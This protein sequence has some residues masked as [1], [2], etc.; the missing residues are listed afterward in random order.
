M[1]LRRR[2]L[3]LGTGVLAAALLAVGVGLHAYVEGPR[4]EAERERVLRS[5]EQAALLLTL[6]GSGRLDLAARAPELGRLLGVRVTLVASDGTVLG[7]SGVPGGDVRNMENHGRRPEVLAALQGRRE[8]VERP[9]P[10]QGIP[11][12]YVA[13]LHALVDGDSVVV[14]VAMPVGSLRGPLDRA[15]ALLLVLGG[16]GFLLLLGLVTAGAADGVLQRGLA[17]MEGGV[18]RATQGDPGALPTPEALPPELRSLGGGLH[19]LVDEVQGR[20]REVLRDRDEL[21][22]L[23]EAIAEGVVALTEDARVLRMNRAAIRLLDVV[24]PAPFAPIGTLVRQPQLRDH[25]EESVVL[26]LPPREFLVGGRNL[27]VS[28]Q[29]LEEGGS[30]VTL[31]DVTE[32]RRSE[33]IR[34][35]FVANASHE[36][37]TPL[38]SMRGFAETLLEGDPPEELRREFLSSIRANTL[39]LQHLVDDLL[40]LSRLEAG[41]WTLQEEEVEL[42]AAAREVWKELGPGAREERVRFSIDGDAVALADGQALHQVFRNLLDNA[43]RYTPDGGSIRVV[44]VSRGPEVEVSVEDSGAG[45]PSSA[46]P[47]IFERFYRADPGRDRVAGGT[48]LGLAIVWH[49]VQSM[50]GEVRAESR[51]GEGTAIRF[52]LPQVEST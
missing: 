40:D 18:F 49:L 6:E 22:V 1:T 29:L 10:T 24:D 45:I 41:A 36:L 43:L 7:D 4:L 16:G 38:T 27:L 37:K 51:L 32:L 3:L 35:D 44:I 9:S 26:R 17:R 34:R 47:R 14:R 46:L 30:V 42:A 48:G 31:L 33:K 39:R 19:R 25:L 8:L 15:P 2:V 13:G 5:W 52:T 21:L 12:F 28:S 20:L 11:T 50:G 23:V